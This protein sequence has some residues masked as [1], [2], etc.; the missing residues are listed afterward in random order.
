MFHCFDTMFRRIRSHAKSSHPAGPLMHPQPFR[1]NR[2]L[3]FAAVLLLFAA[4]LS[5]CAEN[6]PPTLEERAQSVDKRLICPYCPAETIDQAQVPQA[7][8]MRA[9]VREKL[10]EGWTEQQILD[11]FSAP[12]RYGPRVL[13]EPP[14]S[15]FTLT[16]WLLP[17]ATFLLA[18]ILLFFILRSM[19]KPPPPQSPPPTPSNEDDMADYL[20]RVDA[21]ITSRTGSP[22]PP[23]PHPQTR[24]SGESRNPSSQPRY[25]PCDSER[26]QESPS[27]S[28]PLRERIKVRVKTSPPQA[29]SR[30]NQTRHSRTPSRHSRTPSRHSRE[31]GNPLPPTNH[32]NHPKDPPPAQAK[33]NG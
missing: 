20:N 27:L 18:G 29:N 32:P 25:T 16:I 14:K 3:L 1:L 8:E 22:P 5:A 33:I 23:S 15:G 31:S 30:H 9:F 2:L 7:R 11:Y 24:H 6:R 4:S 12:E 17:P 21:E 26:S 19:K 13:A 10:A 28:S